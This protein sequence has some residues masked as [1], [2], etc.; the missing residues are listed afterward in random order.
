[1]AQ[2]QRHLQRPAAAVVALGLLAGATVPAAAGDDPF[3]DSRD[4]VARLRFV[5]A[6]SVYWVDVGGPRSALVTVTSDRGRFEVDGPG[7]QS[8]LWSTGSALLEPPPTSRK[9]QLRTAEGPV[10]AGRP[11]TVVDITSA[12]VLRERVSVDRETGLLLRREQ[13]EQ[14]GRPIRIVS[15]ESLAFLPELPELPELRPQPRPEP[16]GMPPVA[17]HALS[18]AFRVAP[19]LAQGYQ[20]VAAYRQG[21]LVQLVYSDG[22][23]GLS[24]F[25]QPGRLDRGS[26]PD[27]GRPVRLGRWSAVVYDWPGGEA[28]TW[29]AGNLVYTVVGDGPVD[30][31]LAAAASVPGP[32]P[33]SVLS[34]VRQ[35][36]RAIADLLVGR[37]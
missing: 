5:A 29:Q 3:R 12:D 13:Y 6:V 19:S 33:P 11:T 26:L 37:S 28:V 32:P 20:Q 31:V 7:D 35:R 18:P 15:V 10:V 24:V 4:A 21:P 25:A 2:R 16:E 34:Q 36:S 1:V 23:H 30:E 17:L 22:L 8:L 9:Y 27:G 14:G